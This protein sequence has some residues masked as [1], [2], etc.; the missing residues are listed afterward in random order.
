MRVI[1]IVG[2]KG[3]S[4]ID[5]YNDTISEKRPW[6]KDVPKAL[7]VNENG[8]NKLPRD[9]VR[10]DHAV[11]Y[12]VKFLMAKNPSIKFLIVPA[13]KIDSKMVRFSDFV[14]WHFY[15]KLVKPAPKILSYSGKPN[16]RFQKIIDSGKGKMF[17]PIKY[18]HLVYDKCAYYDFFQ[19]RGINT[20]PT[21]CIKRDDRNKSLKAV[22][23]KVWNKAKEWG[24]I[25]G[26]P[27]HGT[28]S[29]D[30]GRP[31]SFETVESLEKYIK[32]VFDSPKKY[33]ALVF[34][35]YIVD[36]E[37]LFPQIRMYYLG[38]K[39][40]YSVVEWKT[41]L[42]NGTSR[43]A[44]SGDSKWVNKAKPFAKRVLKA[45]TPFYKGSPKFLT[46]IDVGC[47]IERGKINA[48][49]LFLN[50]IE[51]LAGLYL[52]YDGKRKMNFEKK[53]AQ[54]VVKVINH[55]NKNVD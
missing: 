18:Q 55:R 54:Q 52:F 21:I 42:P 30:V 11:A 53:M 17:P 5:T 32:Y 34:Q 2:P 38:D 23:R 46:R 15:D 16:G 31:S 19:K 49:S 39:Y 25:F 45:V 12:S 27:V 14:F 9:H 4:Y 37:L 20:A 6:L 1:F 47:C 36:F 50:E 33:P 8:T 51:C 41:P 40:Q 35:K 13:N 10:I 7:K 26:K 44:T 3:K 22:T 28:D 48:K 29:S 43:L 24:D